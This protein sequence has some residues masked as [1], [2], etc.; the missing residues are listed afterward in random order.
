MDVREPQGGSFIHEIIGQGRKR[1]QFRRIRGQIDAHA[2]ALVA[3]SDWS[4]NLTFRAS[5]L[6]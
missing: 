2:Q 4:S 5:T 6:S 3:S 1:L